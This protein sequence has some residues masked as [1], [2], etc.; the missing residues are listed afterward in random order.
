MQWKTERLPPTLAAGTT[1][2][3]LLLQLVT[4]CEEK[5]IRGGCGDLVEK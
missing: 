4:L 5:N 3:S 1:G 2:W